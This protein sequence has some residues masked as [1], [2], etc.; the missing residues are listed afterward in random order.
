MKTYAIPFVLLL[1]SL[2]VCLAQKPDL[3][4]SA[5]PTPP[6]N[7]RRITFMLKNTLGHHRMFRVEGPGISYGFTMN[8]RETVPCHW[9]VGA[10]LYFSQDGESTPGET[11]TGESTRGEST[12]GLILTVAATDEGQTLG[13]DTGAAEIAT[14]K[15]TRQALPDKKLITIRLRNA[16]LRP[17]KVALISYEP[18]ETGNSTSIFTLAPLVGYQIG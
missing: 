1:G 18:G 15:P 11:T 8:R 2:T 7:P 12:R 10:K 5:D 6:A 16:G 9:P 4:A 14:A 17:R 3:P 13:T